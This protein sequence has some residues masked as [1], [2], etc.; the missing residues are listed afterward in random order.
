MRQTR[1]LRPVYAEAFQC[2]GPRCEETCCSGWLV[3]IDLET[4]DRYR[5]A[6]SGELRTLLDRHVQPLPGAAAVPCGKRHAAIGMLPSGACPFLTS[7]SLC[8]I[9]SELG[10]QYLSRTCADY[11]RIPLTIDGLKEQTLMLSCPE[12][13]RLVLLNPNLEL[14]SA[15]DG[16]ELT[17]DDKAGREAPIKAFFWVIRDFT[18]RLVLNRKYAL[19]QRLFLLGAFTRRLGAYAR[20]EIALPFA[21]FLDGFSQAVKAG[22]LAAAMDGIAP[23]LELQLT[24]VVRLAAM[25]LENAPAR[26]ERLRELLREFAEGIGHRPG[27][28]LDLQIARYDAA[29]RECLEPFLANHEHLLE[30]YL[31]NQL[32]RGM[33]PFGP[34]SGD[35]PDGQAFAESYA[36]LVTRFALM[37]GMLIGVAGSRGSALTAGDVVRTVETVTRQFEHNPTFLS[38]AMDRLRERNALDPRG[39]TMLLRN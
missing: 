38:D 21:E 5:S 12:A 22:S 13:A 30:N 36:G 37:K 24:M 26:T 3:T 28:P 18:I 2:I 14:S 20:G 25:H 7:R 31:V 34:E 27:A 10:E 16:H 4:F 23:D 39:L 11:P 8:R 17:W 15:N 19:W 32:F 35:R 29:W 6:P 9:Q 1:L 33:Y